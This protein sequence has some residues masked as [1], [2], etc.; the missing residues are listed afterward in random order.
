MV[1][2]PVIITKY[3]P[4]HFRGTFMGM[5]AASQYLG[6]GIGAILGGVNAGIQQSVH[7]NFGISALITVL[8]ILITLFFL[9]N[10]KQQN[11]KHPISA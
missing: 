6:M 10:E 3:I 2:G 11:K 8:L 9:K 1:A 7:A 5:F 4:E